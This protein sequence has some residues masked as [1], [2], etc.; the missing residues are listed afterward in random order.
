M[1]NSEFSLSFIGKEQIV[2]I[3]FDHLFLHKLLTTVALDGFSLRCVINRPDG[4]IKNSL[5]L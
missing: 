2:E 1:V 4:G 5:F 3:T